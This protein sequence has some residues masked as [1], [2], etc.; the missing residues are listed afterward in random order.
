MCE[1]LT[2]PGCP[3]NRSSRSASPRGRPGSWNNRCTAS[4]LAC[5]KFSDW[6]DAMRRIY[7]LIPPSHC[8]RARSVGPSR[9]F[10]GRGARRVVPPD[11]WEPYVAESPRWRAWHGASQFRARLPGTM[12]VC[13]ADNPKD[14]GEAGY[15]VRI[16]AGQCKIAGPL[17]RVTKDQSR[18]LV[19]T[20]NGGS[21]PLAAVIAPLPKLIVRVRFSS[22]ALDVVR[23]QRRQLAQGQ[24][25]KLG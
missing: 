9:Q 20:R 8:P 3:G 18:L 19:D 6:R 15:D 23:S 7:L 16:W 24:C 10:R 14:G 12:R 25:P 2:V 17:A 5:W 11:W 22:P 21:A 1:A 13:D 4:W